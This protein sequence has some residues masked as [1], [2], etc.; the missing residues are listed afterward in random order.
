MLSAREYGFLPQTT[1][2]IADRM[3]HGQCWA[4]QVVRRMLRLA[5]QE[6]L[7]Q[8]FLLVS[9]ACVPMYPPTVL[10]ASLMADDKSR[11]NACRLP[12]WHRQAE[13]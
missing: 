13:R 2:C 1:A 12:G 11:I 3:Q 4:L 6:P 9:E 8:R 10:Y 7:N 5:L